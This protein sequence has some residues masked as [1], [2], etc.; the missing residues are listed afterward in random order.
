[1]SGQLELLPRVGLEV[2]PEPGRMEPRFWV[3]RLVIWEKPGMLLREIALRP[4]LNIVWS[5]DPAD[6][7]QSP[8]SESAL[9]HGSGKTLFCRLLRYVLGEDRFSPDDQR[10]LI[11]QAYPE[12]M[13]GAEV[14]I[15]GTQWA[16]M[17]PIGG[18]RQHFAVPEQE[19]RREDHPQAAR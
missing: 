8:E 14:M 2:Q 3:R 9:G 18:G 17:R 10:F 11:A 6:R 19:A 7:G 1:M 12:G 13:V 5:P 16:V 15:G 4:G